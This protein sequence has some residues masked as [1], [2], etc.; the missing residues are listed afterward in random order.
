MKNPAK[1]KSTIEERI[2]IIAEVE[3]IEKR[4]NRRKVRESKSKRLKERKEARK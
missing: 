3:W 2:A 1:T 4:T